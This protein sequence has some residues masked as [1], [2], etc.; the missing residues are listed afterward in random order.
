M[1]GVFRDSQVNNN[2]K[3]I[4]STI[5]TVFARTHVTQSQTNSRGNI[6]ILKQQQQDRRKSTFYIVFFP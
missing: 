6:E 1:T 2:S 4:N 3:W 5:E